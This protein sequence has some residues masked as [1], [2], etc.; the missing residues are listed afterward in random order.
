MIRNNRNNK[1]VNVDYTNRN[2]AI[3]SREDKTGKLRT[4]TS[5]RDEGTVQFAMST[6]PKSNSTSLYI[7][8]PEGAVRLSGS[9]ARTLYRL[10][11]KHYT[12]TGKSL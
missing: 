8:L 9:E 5:G 12:F 7:D 4:E 1:N 11:S 10:L 6:S 2:A 3:V